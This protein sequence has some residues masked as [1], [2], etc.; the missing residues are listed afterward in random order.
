MAIDPGQDDLVPLGDGPAATV[1]AGVD[2]AAGQAYALK[3]F[4]G[5]LD[6][7][8]R[9]ELDR[10]LAAL[11]ALR[12]HAPV[13]V[14]DAVDVTT[15]GHCVLRMELCTQSLAEMVRTFGPM[16][17]PE[18]LALGQVLASTL[19][20][21]HQAGIVHGSVTPGNVLFLPSGE[22]VLA[23]FG[24][25]LRQ[26]FP[27]DTAGI[28]DFAA[29]ET[30]RDGTADERSDLYGLGAVLY[31][32]LAGKSPH[33]GPPGEQPGDRVLRVLGA[34]VTSLRTAG[35]PAGLDQLVESLLAK[36]ADARPLDATAV[37]TR[38]GAMVGPRQ[39]VVAPRPMGDPI[40]VY[41]PTSNRRRLPKS[42]PLI[43]VLAVLAVLAV[44]AVVLLLNS[45]AELEMPTAVTTPPA[46]PDVELAE[47]VDRMTFV[48]LSWRS[49]VPLDFAVHITPEGRSSTTQF[50][51]RSTTA[52]LPVE[53][54]GK[55]CFVVQ[56]TDSTAVYLSLPRGIRGATCTR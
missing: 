52:R 38:L 24:V 42:A 11:R 32:A 28:V 21:A 45:P 25:T 34:K 29:P 14:A 20:A 50:V 36:N 1:L 51:Q 49:P 10:E 15:D 48:E 41:G 7:H 47:P 18:A 5:R 12:G 33:E 37:A 53:P 8:T 54:A 22:A 44:T 4:P 39:S 6:R 9:A 31:F 56:G 26:A 35:L 19:V 27:P 30:L 3:I 40:V 55:Y 16:A 17:V 23:D 43:A 46:T 2:E 13:L